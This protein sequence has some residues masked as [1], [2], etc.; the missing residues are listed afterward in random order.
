MANTEIILCGI[1][2]YLKRMS[3]EGMY[4]PS[5]QHGNMQFGVLWP[6]LGIWNPS[7]KAT[8]MFPIQATLNK[9]G[10]MVSLKIKVMTAVSFPR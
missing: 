6:Y 9:Q 2:S 3:K 8:E 1:L 10:T 4:L 5:P 7:S